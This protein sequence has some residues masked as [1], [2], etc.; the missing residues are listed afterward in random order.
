MK[1]SK[2]LTFLHTKIL[3]I[4]YK[5][6]GYLL[7]NGINTVPVRRL[8]I[9][10]NKIVMEEIQNKDWQYIVESIIKLVEHD[11]SHLK[12]LPKAE[13][14]ILKSMKYNMAEQFKIYLNSLPPDKIDEI[15]NDFRANGNGLLSVRQTESATKLFYSFAMFYYINDRFPYMDGHLFS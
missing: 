15:E 4:F 3:N 1:L 7:F 8:K 12:L 14:K 10:E 13:R 9:N 6:N 5:F 11:K 2:N